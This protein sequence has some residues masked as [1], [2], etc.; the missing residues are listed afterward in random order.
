MEYILKTDSSVLAVSLVEAKAY[1]QVD[2]STDDA[3]I[4]ELIKSFL[5]ICG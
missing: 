1:L 3:L 5:E 4:T 2:F